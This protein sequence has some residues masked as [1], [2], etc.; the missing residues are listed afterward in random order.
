[1]ND[2]AIRFRL[3][4]FVLGAFILLGVL[5]V[6]FGGFP[7]YF[8]ST[9]EY[10]IV[11]DSAPGVSPGTPVR[12]SGVRIG[13]VSRLDLNNDTGKVEVVIHVDTS[14]SLRRQDE[15]VLTQGLLGGDSTIDFVSRPPDGKLAGILEPGSKIE[16]KVQ[17]DA[18]SVVG[19]A[20]ST[21][22]K[23]N[24]LTP[25]MKETLEEYR[26]LGKTTRVTIPEMQ[27]K[28]DAATNELKEAAER[29]KSAG[30]KF[31]SLLGD[32]RTKFDNAIDGLNKMFSDKNQKNLTEA[33]ENAK[34][35]GEM[36]S[37][38]EGVANDARDMFRAGRRTF[39]SFDDTRQ[40]ANEAI[41]LLK[42]TLKPFSE[43]SDTM[44]RNFDESAD[45]L[46]KLL[47]DMRDLMQVI[48]RSEGTVQKLLTDPTLYD[49]LNASACMITRIIPR[50]DRILR[51][52]EIFADKIARHPE[53]LGLGGVIRPGSGL[54]DAPT[55]LP[56]RGAH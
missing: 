10:T 24:E 11:F 55:V 45:R 2:Q 22:E 31:D 14:R 15:A 52:M 18:G 27:K 4:I 37:K 44:A 1:M 29:W 42:K 28:L 6:L 32:N 49:N 25:L 48:A 56:W 33:L 16:G 5:V 51:D 20:K 41:D 12:R 43:R 34:K 21:M 36:S 3:G 39:E 40:R 30:K 47:T 23:F 54:K 13:E 50:L 38:M 7:D 8:R 35:L 19:P 46:N 26:N 9:D 17:A 53:S